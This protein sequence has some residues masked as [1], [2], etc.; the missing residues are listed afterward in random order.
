MLEKSG[1][2]LHL[3]GSHKKDY[4]KIII[5]G[6]SINF[7][8]PVSSS[9]TSIF[10]ALYLGQS[11]EPIFKAAEGLVTKDFLEV[12]CKLLLK[13]TRHTESPRRSAGSKDT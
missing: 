12:A 5:S 13:P 4:T 2:V 3:L 8:A 9:I 7:N 11:A 6:E 10:V 1:H